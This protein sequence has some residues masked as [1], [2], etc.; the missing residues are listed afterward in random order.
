MHSI[1]WENPA[2]IDFGQ[3]LT[4]RKNP[5]L[6]VLVH[7]TVTHLN[8]GPSGREIES[9]EVTDGNGKRRLVRARAV[10]WTIR[11]ISS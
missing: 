1:W 7:A 4:T 8:T 2:Y 3:V 10:S 5:N 6:W 9:V 11:A